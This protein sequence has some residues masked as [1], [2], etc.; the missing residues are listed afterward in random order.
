MDVPHYIPQRPVVLGGL[1]SKVVGLDLT[2]LRG[3]AYRQVLQLQR[4]EG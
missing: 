1:A 4:E 2:P 3:R